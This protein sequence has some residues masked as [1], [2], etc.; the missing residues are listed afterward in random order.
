[1]D[2][3]RKNWVSNIKIF[4]DTFFI[5][6][7][8]IHI[9]I[10]NPKAPWR[11]DFLNLDPTNWERYDIDWPE[12][13][14]GTLNYL[15][16]GIPP[17]V[18]QNY[19]QRYMTFWNQHLPDELNR[20]LYLRNPFAKYIPTSTASTKPYPF[21]TSPSGPHVNYYLDR[22]TENPI[23]TLQY[24]LHHPNL[25]RSDVYQI[26][27]TAGTASPIPDSANASPE[28]TFM[29]GDN[30]II[31]KADSTLH[32]LI[33][34]VIIFLLINVVI[35]LIYVIR[36][37]YYSKNLKRKLDV[38][39]LDGTT[40]D[41][42]KRSAKFNDG[43]ESFIL[44]IGRRKNEY[45]PVKR[46]HS[47]INGFLLSRQYSTSTVDTHT[48]VSD[49][50]AQE[51]NRQQNIKSAEEKGTASP[52]FLMGGSRTFF[53]K[54]A[55]PSEAGVD[56]GP[57]SLTTNEIRHPSLMKSKSFESQTK[58]KIICE[59]IN[60]RTD[61]LDSVD[62]RHSNSVPSIKE[63]SSDRTTDFLLRIDHRHTRSDP[64]EQPRPFIPKEEITSFIEDVDVNVT[65]RDECDGAA[66]H[67][68]LSPEE[69][70]QL[71]QMRNY[72]KVLPN[73]PEGSSEYVS[74]SSFKRRSMPSYQHLVNQCSRMP[75]V[76]PPRSSSTLGR[77]SSFRTSG[78]S[79]SSVLVPTMARVPERLSPPD[80]EPEITY[81]AL[82]VGPLL[83]GSKENLYSTM[84]RRQIQNQKSTEATNR[85]HQEQTD[86]NF[87]EN[88]QKL[89]NDEE[90]SKQP[91]PSGIKQPTSY[92]CRDDRSSVIVQPKIVIKPNITRQNSSDTT[93]QSSNIPRVHA[94]PDSSHY[95]YATPLAPTNSKIPTL[96]G[97]LSSS[98]TSNSS[99]S[100]ESNSS[101]SSS[102]CD[103][104]HT[105]N[106]INENSSNNIQSTGTDE[107]SKDNEKS[108]DQTNNSDNT[109]SASNSSTE[110]SSSSAETVKQ[111][112]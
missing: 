22:T 83:P 34:M 15:N 108:G 8:I 92:K 110:T 89:Q 10:S 87:S 33:G 80:E 85:E 20:T 64:V 109:R 23:R 2:Q 40:D 74:A 46:Y 95:A 67:F 100:N 94:P 3:F 106:T 52:S 35:I 29:L 77:R 53:G 97:V 93:K 25:N 82:H 56:I 27:S 44:D 39:S 11:D 9:K 41:E 19:R 75:P 6:I 103:N 50:I 111:I 26:Q 5:T 112:F 21:D 66:S 101:N 78:S 71:Y 18:N 31:V 38:L 102:N 90:K 69:T 81:N 48:K 12:F 63:A 45:V 42:L 84:N 7:A 70:L 32:V 54:G 17:V 47:P 61:L 104:N 88:E 65:S 98:N 1:M 36:R 59:E 105:T 16:I 60:V 4:K 72:P 73:Y 76:P 30:K 24:L 68:P 37:N 28:N 58:D 43:D 91:R 14:A 107:N 62:L 86:S 49:W 96:K 13:N 51:V 55:E 99:S 79:G 57:D